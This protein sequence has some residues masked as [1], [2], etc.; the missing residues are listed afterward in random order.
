M[1]PMRKPSVVDTSL[2]VKLL[3]VVALA[4]CS[5]IKNHALNGGYGINREESVTRRF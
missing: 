4:H 5:S 2:L 1:S 3:Y